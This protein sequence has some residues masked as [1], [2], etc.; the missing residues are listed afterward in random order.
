MRIETGIDWDSVR[1]EMDAEPWRDRSEWEGDGQERRVYLGSV[2]SLMPSGKYYTPFAC[3][4][5]DPCPVCEGSGNVKIRQS[6]RR[7][8][9]MRIRARRIDRQCGRILATAKT[10]WM[11]IPEP[12]KTR[13]RKLRDEQ[14]RYEQ[15]SG[16]EKTCPRCAGLGSAEAHDDEVFRELLEEEAESHG[17]GI[18]SGEGDPCDLFV[19][20]YRDRPEEEEQE[21]EGTDAED[22]GEED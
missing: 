22:S 8:A 1:A 18:E 9:R 17:F 5:V 2:F 12:Q 6:K 4:N 13:F 3:S 10:G 15:I 20:E 21:E 11:N 14:A 7:A 19:V 16:A